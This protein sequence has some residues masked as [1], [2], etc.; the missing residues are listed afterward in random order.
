MFVDTGS[1]LEV[2]VHVKFCDFYKLES[3]KPHIL[4]KWRFHIQS[5]SDAKFFFGIFWLKP[6]LKLEISDLSAWRV[7]LDNFLCI[8]S[9]IWGPKGVPIQRAAKTIM[10]HS[11]DVENCEDTSATMVE[12]GEI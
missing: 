8:E 5:A 1:K 2:Y 3:E 6:Y 12:K 4:C 9:T 10:L 11:C 7:L